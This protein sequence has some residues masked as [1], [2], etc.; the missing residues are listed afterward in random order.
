MDPIEELRNKL[1]T[2]LHNLR[3]LVEQGEAGIND[4]ISLRAAYT[5]ENGYIKGLLRQMP[6]S[7]QADFGRRLNDFIDFFEQTF[8]DFL[9]EFKS[10]SGSL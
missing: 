9:D 1:T 10:P 6:T 2:D 3:T 4:A 7:R 5:G 8:S